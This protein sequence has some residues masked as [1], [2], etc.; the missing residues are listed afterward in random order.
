M[1]EIYGNLT[2]R[3]DQQ[4]DMSSHIHP[5]HLDEV[6]IC[7]PLKHLMLSAIIASE[8]PTWLSSTIQEKDDLELSQSNYFCISSLPMNM[9]MHYCTSSAEPGMNLDPDHLYGKNK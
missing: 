6:K 9:P 8:Y 7:R 3:S 4:P 1:A 5:L 2:N